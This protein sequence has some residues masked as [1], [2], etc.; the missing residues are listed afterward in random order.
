MLCT[1]VPLSTAGDFKQL[2][3]AT[4]KQPFICHTSV[5]NQL[6]FRVLR[7]NRRVRIDDDRSKESEA[8]HSALSNV[9]EGLVTADVMRLVVEAYVRGAPVGC[10][11]K[12]EVEGSTSVFTKR[13]YRDRWNRTLVRRI[14]RKCS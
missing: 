4:S 9:A 14:I 13:R 7:E 1:C 10:A 5:Y 3:P 8:F 11:E 2:P 6:D 12:A